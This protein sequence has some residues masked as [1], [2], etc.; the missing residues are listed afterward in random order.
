MGL[1]R[2]RDQ[3]NPR[4][5]PPQRAA[6]DSRDAMLAGG[7]GDWCEGHGPRGGASGYLRSVVGWPARGTQPA[8]WPLPTSG[9][10]DLPSSSMSPLESRTTAATL[11]PA[12]CLSPQRTAT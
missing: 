6:P 7:E 2:P 12:G 8:I 1:D 10:S 9:N 3:A 4:V 11:S 5:S